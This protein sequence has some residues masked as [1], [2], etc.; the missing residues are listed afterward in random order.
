MARSAATAA[1][2]RFDAY[3]LKDG[4]KLVINAVKAESSKTN[5]SSSVNAAITDGNFPTELNG[6]DPVKRFPLPSAELTT[7]Q[8]RVRNVPPSH[9]DYQLNNSLTQFLLVATNLNVPVL[10]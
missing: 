6:P 4:S 10:M 2:V 3:A 9:M 5:I 8:P 7:H 1:K